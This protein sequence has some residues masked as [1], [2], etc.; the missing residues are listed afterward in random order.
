MTDIRHEIWRLLDAARPASRE[1]RIRQIERNLASSGFEMVGEAYMQ[2][3][4]GKGSLD[5]LNDDEVEMMLHYVNKLTSLLYTTN[6]GS[7]R[8]Q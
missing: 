5:D 3:A 1:S 7:D 6:P 4:F 2:Q 8:L